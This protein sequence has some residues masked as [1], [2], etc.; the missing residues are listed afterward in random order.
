M[1]HAARRRAG[2]ADG[3]QRVRIVAS[4]AGIRRDRRDAA[5]TEER[6]TCAAR[7]AFAVL[8]DERQVCSLRR[9][10]AAALPAR[11]GLPLRGARRAAPLR[12][13]HPRRARGAERRWP[14]P[15]RDGDRVSR[16]RGLVSAARRG[17]PRWPR[18]PL[19]RRVAAVG[20][21]AADAARRLRHRRRDDDRGPGVAGHGRV[22]D[23]AAQRAARRDLRLRR[24]L[25]RAHADPQP[26]P[27]RRLVAVGPV[28]RRDLP[29][30][31]RDARR[32]R[33]L[34]AQ[35][36]VRDRRAPPRRRLAVGPAGLYFLHV[37]RSL[38]RGSATDG[39]R[40]R[41]PRAAQA[42]SGHAALAEPAAER[43]ALGAS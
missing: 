28:A 9:A 29:D 42:G 3:L 8:L 16:R 4:R 19:R 39:N 30:L 5:R 7:T 14:G 31:R 21:R 22:R 32:V 43:V 1:G 6:L 15:R 12:A 26:P 34:R 37:V 33:L 24:L 40:M 41:A 36:R 10:A 35:R 13:R 38:Y 25:R 17:V 18:R 11:A 23:G 20:A 2:Q 27:A